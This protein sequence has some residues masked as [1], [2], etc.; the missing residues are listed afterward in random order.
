[1]Q[2]KVLYLPS[3][4]LEV[5]MGKHSARYQAPLPAVFSKSAPV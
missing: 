2:T 1:M 3:G 5:I 4:L